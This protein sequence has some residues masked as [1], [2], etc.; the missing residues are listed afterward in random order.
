MLETLFMIKGKGHCLLNTYNLNKTADEW[1]TPGLKKKEEKKRFLL[2]K[3]INTPFCILN[4]CDLE[5]IL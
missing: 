2:L 5:E 1:L 4:E 3:L